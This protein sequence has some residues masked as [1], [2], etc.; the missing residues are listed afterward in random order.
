MHI[1]NVEIYSD[2]PNAAVIR[3]PGRRFPGVLIQG[4]LLYSLCVQADDACAVARSKLGSDAYDELNELRNA[5]WGYL[6][7]YKSVLG[8]HQISL[9]F[10]EDAG[11]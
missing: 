4:D 6:N 2:Q 8:E 5:L 1:D 10:G 11:A 7:H 3:H 9:P